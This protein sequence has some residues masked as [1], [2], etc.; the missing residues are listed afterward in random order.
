MAETAKPETAPRRALRGAP[1]AP[2]TLGTPAASASA[3]VAVAAGE[4][5]GGFL[6]A[7]V[8]DLIAA[9][10][11]SGELAPGSVLKAAGIAAQL[12]IS[13]A[14]VRRALALLAGAGSIRAAEGQG[15]L[16]GAA[17]APLHLSPRRLQEILAPEVE[18]IDRS[19]A[20]E[21]ILAE[22]GAT[23]AAAM[24]FGTY[25]VQ[26]AELGAH[27]DVSRTVARE[28]L[29]RLVDLR[30]I[31]KDRKSHWIAGQMTA[32]DLRE[33]LEMRRVLEPQALLRV[34]PG[35]PAARLAA[36]AGA[37][38]AA[39]ADFPACGAAAVDAIEHE[40]FVALFDGLQN[41]RMLGSI[42]RN[43][44]SLLVPRLFRAHFPMVDD[45]PLLRDY[46]QIVAEWRGGRLSVAQALLRSHL[47]RAEPLIL[48]R[49][50]VLSQLPP[51]RGVPYL[52]A[53]H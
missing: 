14:P 48:A 6:Y 42:R 43:Q 5:P 12:G 47:Q 10:I 35:L 7:S 45:L 20:S 28:V 25:R 26:E 37:I 53:I 36:L 46:A 22:V 17:G 39:L 34:A 29:W 50:R 24:P 41:S 44:I 3:A 8:R 16:V 40:L 9:R 4:R 13:R 15:Y 33:T 30:L 11:A 2:E 49:L 21:R 32:R 18:A 19:A 38:G 1:G 23:I 27:F 51:P 31:E 52:A